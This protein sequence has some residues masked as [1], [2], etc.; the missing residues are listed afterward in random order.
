MGYVF[1]PEI[2]AVPSPP[3]QAVG[4]RLRDPDGNLAAPS[5]PDVAFSH[6]GEYRYSV[7]DGV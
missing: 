3:A 5:S 4:F 7:R 2:I 6:G 1:M